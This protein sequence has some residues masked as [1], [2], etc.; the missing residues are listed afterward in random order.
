M[1]NVY[2][3]LFFIQQVKKCLVVLIQHQVVLFQ[4]H[5]SGKCTLYSISV[6]SV[7]LRARYPRYIHAAK[8][9][10]GD[11]G[12]LICED[13]LQQGRSLMSQVRG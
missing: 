13:I 3:I 7:H 10:Y 4:T 12:K 9:L 8:E 2:S 11:T 6:E 1:Y 5:T